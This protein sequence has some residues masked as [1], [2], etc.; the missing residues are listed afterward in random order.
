[1]SPR[2]IDGVLFRVLFVSAFLFRDTLMNMA[3]N[4]VFYG[5]MFVT[6]FRDV[7]FAYY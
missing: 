4:T 2:G 3:I 6:V 7:F 1:M 5:L